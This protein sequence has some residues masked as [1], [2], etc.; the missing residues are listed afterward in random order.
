MALTLQQPT[1]TASKTKSPWPQ[2][3]V[4]GL[5]RVSGKHNHPARPGLFIRVSPKLKAVYGYRFKDFSGSEVSGTLGLAADQ[6]GEPA[7]H[8]DEATA[9]FDVLFAKHRALPAPPPPPK[10]TLDAAY[11]DWLDNRVKRGGEGKPLAPR[12]IDYY[13]EAYDRYLAE[14][15]GTLP[16]DDLTVEDWES[17]LA[18]AKARSSSQCRGLFWSLHAMYVE[19]EEKGFIT[20]NPFATRTL[21]DKFAIKTTVVRKGNVPAI[22]LKPFFE[23]ILSLENRHSRDAGQLYLFTGWRRM[24]ILAMKWEHIDFENKVYT[25]QEGSL[26]WKA[27][28]GQVPLSSYAIAVLEARKAEVRKAAESEWVFPARHGQ[29]PYMTDVNESLALASKPLGY[30]I[31]AHDLRR[32]F[33]TIGEVVTGG[34]LRLI[35]KLVGHKFTD[36]SEQVQTSITQNYIVDKLEALNATVTRINEAMLEIADQVPLDDETVEIFKRRG[37]AIQEPLVFSETAALGDNDSAD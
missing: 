4:A 9:L 31:T 27:W 18:P 20:R 16:V 29:Y 8:V 2:S 5:T 35:G 10:T 37:I 26:G 6:P 22:N 33:L 19:R 23:N 17:L 13:R 28:T 3:I 1:A 32:T 11:A 25:V 7:L 34:N 36:D 12:T 24:A 21:R 30:R 14:A 15:N